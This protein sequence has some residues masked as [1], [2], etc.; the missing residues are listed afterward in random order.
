MV[1]RAALLLRYKEPAVRWINNAD[2]SPTNAPLSLARINEE[3]TVYLIRDATGDSPQTLQRWLKANYETLFEIE[4]ES[5]HTEP[6]LWPA[7][8]TFQLFQEWFD[9]ELHTVLLDTVGTDI[10]DDGV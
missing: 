1:N 8:R 3:R 4:L 9:T 2:P 10:I 5:W 7:N 6:S